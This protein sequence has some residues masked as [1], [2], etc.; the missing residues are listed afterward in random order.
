M[1][2]RRLIRDCSGGAE[3]CCW[4]SS[5]LC[6]EDGILGDRIE[7]IGIPSLFLL[8]LLLALLLL[9]VV[10][11]VMTLL[12]YCIGEGGRE[13]GLLLSALDGGKYRGGL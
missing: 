13:L 12:A 11:V 6:E 5:C 7:D 8:V 10:V 4:S 3:H 2:G 1:E 9:L